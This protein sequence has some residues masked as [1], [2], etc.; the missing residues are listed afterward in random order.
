MGTNYFVTAQKTTAVTSASVGNFT[1]PDDL[2][3]IL[4]RNSRFEIFCVSPEGLKPFKEVNIN[5]RISV[6]KLFRPKGETKDLMFILTAKYNA[7]ILEYKNDEIITRAHGN[8][9]DRIGRASETGFIVI[10]DPTCRVI[11]LRLYDGLFKVIQWQSES[12]ELKAFNIRFE[13]L[14]VIDIDFLH[15]YSQPTVAFIH[16]DQQGRHVVTYEVN[17]RDKEFI[18]GPWKQDGVESEAS[19]LIAVPSP[20]GGVLVIGQESITYIRRESQYFVVAPGIIK[21]SMINCFGR[22][23][24]DGSRYILGDMAGRLFMLVLDLEEQMDGGVNVRDLKVEYLGE[25]T[26]PECLTYLDNGV[27][28]I[29]SRLG[30]SQL[31]RLNQEADERGSYI[32]V[33]DTYTNLGPIVDMVVVDLERQ[34]QGQLITCSGFAK[35]GSL[36]IIRNGIGIHELATMDLPGIKGLWALAYKTSDQF[37]N[38]MVVSLVTRTT[39]LLI[40]GEEVEA[41]ELPGM[42]H[43]KRTLFAASFGRTS[44]I[45]QVTTAG[46]RLISTSGADEGLLSEWH[47]SDGRNVNVVCCNAVTG[48]L[49]AAS[50]R[51]LYYLTISDKKVTQVNTTKLDNEVACLD[52]SPIGV[53][54]KSEVFAVGLWMEIS[55]LLIHVPSMNVVTKESL[56]GDIIP[57]S[58]MLYKFEALIYLLVALGD[59]TLLYYHVDEKTGQLLDRKKVTLGTQPIALRT[60]ESRSIKNVFACSDR[61]TVIYCNNQKLLF[62]NVNLRIVTHMCPLNA[63]AY[64]DSLAMT[65]GRTLMIGTVDDIQ[66]LHIRTVPLGETPR[67]IAYQE[68][69]QTFGVL[70]IRHEFIDASLVS[71]PSASVLAQSVSRG[72]PLLKSSAASTD[73]AGVVKTPANNSDADEQEIHNF[74]I[75]DQNTF[76]VIH[77]HQFTANEQGCSVISC[78]FADDPAV[79][80][81]VGTAVVYPD[82]SDAKTGRLLVFQY[83]PTGGSSDG[84]TGGGDHSSVRLFEWTTGPSEKELHLECSYF[85]FINA[86]YLKTKGDFILAGDLQ[87][88]I[89]VL[90]YKSVESTLEQI[91]QDYQPNWMTAVEVIDDDTFLGAENSFNLFTSQKDSTATTDEDRQRLQTVG[92][93]HLGEMVNVFRHGSLVMQHPGEACAPVSSPILFGTVQG[94]IGLIC[95][96]PEHFFKFLH[97][98]EIRLS[99]TIKSVG[100]IEHASWRR[101]SAERRS[102]PPFGFID[103]DLIECL[104]D[105]PRNKIAECVAGLE[106]EDQTGTKTLATPED[107]IKIVEELSR[108]H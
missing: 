19:M 40:D 94:A 105:L 106:V 22:V 46:V 61:P 59:G 18:K 60:F 51:D 49:V 87:R 56:G 16:Q 31:V 11:G 28:F 76:E 38:L 66:K 107:V 108:I 1:D 95:Q 27:L 48:Q 14:N 64:P 44:S 90:T 37:N 47:P 34:G 6:M 78:K 42:Q 7:A 68:E 103:G 50:G 99:K 15:G 58:L 20:I 97:E 17:L 63:K 55:V 92:M 96:V 36:R 73:I 2:N 33:L 3:L 41:V 104:L 65:D 4:V 52:M 57:R 74:L 32:S 26:I 81:V 102:E 98:L 10:I 79:Y 85:C 91:A 35:E 12:R 45:I 5:G 70:T 72:S 23:D 88:S 69:T 89:T 67:R 43:D 53:Y 39:A 54:N 82:D 80:Y 62:S 9:S 77:A 83:C 84:N 100:K 8:V 29:G 30:D 13:E 24:K 25:I 101:F 21:Q 75:L 86:L 71:R 93:F